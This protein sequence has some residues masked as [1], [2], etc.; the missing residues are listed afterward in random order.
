[1]E[2]KVTIPEGCEVDSEKSTFEN[3][4]FKKIKNKYL[5]S[6]KEIKGRNWHTGI[7]GGVHKTETP[8]IDINQLST[9]DRAAA[10]LALMQLVELRDAWNKID[11]GVEWDWCDRN[12]AIE[13][14]NNKIQ[15]DYYIG[16]YKVLHFRKKETKDSFLDTFR[17]LIKTAR[18]LL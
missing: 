9:K 14:Y 13:Y 16:E 3:I 11:G 15:V 12:Y 2:V 1:M 4:V 5:V 17:V 18:E 8:Y 7:T 6:V 10:F